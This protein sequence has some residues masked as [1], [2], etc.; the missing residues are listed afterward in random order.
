MFIEQ[1]K[2][3]REE[4]EL[5]LK[6]IGLLIET[7]ASEEQFVGATYAEEFRNKQKKPKNDLQNQLSALGD[8][9]FNVAGE[10]KATYKS[11]AAHHQENM[12]GWEI[13]NTPNFIS[14][15]KFNQVNTFNRCRPFYP[16][17]KE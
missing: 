15:E 16:L 12:S 2:K 1:A 13:Q 10:T 4:I 6:E 17:T 3:Q 8:D 11:A 7:L 5:K 9:V 14:S